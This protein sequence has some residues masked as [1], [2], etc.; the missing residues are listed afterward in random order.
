MDLDV[1][2]LGTGPSVP[3]ARRN[4][5]ATLIRIGGDRLLFDCGEG[6]QRQMQQSTGLVALDDIFITHLHAD[7]YLG[8][9]GLIKTFDLGDRSE[10]L[11]IYGPRGLISLWESIRRITGT[12]GY[13]VELVEMEA[14]EALERDGYAVACFGVDHRVAANGY[15]LF[16][17]ARPGHLDAGLAERLGVPPG[18]AF[19]E[20]QRGSAVQVPDGSTVSP[21]QVMGA[22][23]PGRKIV[24]TGDTRPCEATRIAAHQAQLLV[25]DSSFM[26]SESERAGE[27]GHST[28]AQAAEV[29]RD[30]EVELLALVH[31]SGRHFVPEVLEEARSIF[32]N[33]QAPRD[34]D[35]V[36][37]PF[38]E[39]G[40][41]ELVE[42]GSRAG[43]GP[44]AREQLAA[45]SN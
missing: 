31:I 2:F 33:A 9:P 36:E 25:H 34:F 15:A 16:E 22:E 4:T 24:I 6:T 27:T 13:P 39:R 14:G 29:A 20:L 17:P 35:L 37:I 23:R 41:P 30:A 3:S 32:P 1:I 45:E 26:A 42:N 5:A 38:P 7:H 11:R 10:P 18:P 21:D 12:A 40:A 43:K 28:A 8:L 19:G 44:P